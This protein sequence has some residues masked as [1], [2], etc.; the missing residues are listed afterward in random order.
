MRITPRRVV[1]LASAVG[2]MAAVGVV[3]ATSSATTSSYSSADLPRPASAPPPPR[4]GD[5]FTRSRLLATPT[6]RPEPDLERLGSVIHLADKP[7]PR[8]RT[9]SVAEARPDQRAGCPI[10]RPGGPRPPRVALQNLG[11]PMGRASDPGWYGN[12]VLWTELPPGLPA[13]RAD[14]RTW[15]PHHTPM[16]GLKV[17]WNRA[18]P[19]AVSITA[20][21]LHGSPAL[22]IAQTSTV[23]EYGPR[24]FIPSGLEF[25]RPGCWRVTARLGDHVLPVVLD[26]PSP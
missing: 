6:T 10:T 11:Q 19:G 5:P 26:V 16:V 3:L 7:N 18:L 21:P 22:F 25:A 23:Q 20:H 8:G 13:D 24:G 17:G 15:G 12:G 9:S 4:R 1:A 14:L 2:L